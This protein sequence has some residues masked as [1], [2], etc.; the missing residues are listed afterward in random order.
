MKKQITGIVI[1][2]VML[3]SFWGNNEKVQAAKTVKIQLEKAKVTLYAGEYTTI[4]P[5]LKNATKAQKAKVKFTY[6][7][8]NKSVAQVTKKG[9][10]N[11]K[12]KGT[13]VIT[14][15]SN[16]SKKQKANFKVVVKAKPAKS[17]IKL[18]EDS[19]NIKVGETID[20]KVKKIT[21]VSSKEIE[22]VSGNKAIAT[23]SSSGKVTGKK[24]GK[25]TITVKSAVNQKVKAKYTV[26][27]SKDEETQEDTQQETNG[28]ENYLRAGYLSVGYNYTLGSWSDPAVN[29][30]RKD[31]SGN[32]IY[33]AL[34]KEVESRIVEACGGKYSETTD[35]TIYTSQTGGFEN[36]NS[37]VDNL[38]VDLMKEGK[39]KHIY[40]MIMRSDSGSGYNILCK[41]NYDS[42]DKEICEHKE[43]EGYY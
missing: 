38:T 40:L 7:S 43:V 15:T 4:K 21:G 16:V 37:I 12:K 8:G 33:Q 42:Y 39:V 9:I 24:E 26:T 3:L 41:I 28:D 18:N 6:K 35:L 31:W 36:L 2:L 13:A 10:V 5:K 14:V 25:T 30:V 23:V 17:I 34:R 1:V 32:K 27:V 22:Y 20:I 11:A 19:A 29:F